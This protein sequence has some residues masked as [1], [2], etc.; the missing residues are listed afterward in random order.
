MVQRELKHLNEMGIVIPRHVGNLCL[1]QADEK[2]PIYSELKSLVIK[3]FGVAGEI[4]NALNTLKEDIQFAFIFGSFAIGEF[5]ARSDIDLLIVTSLSFRK[6]TSA[7]SSVQGILAREINPVVFSTREMREK[8]RNHDGF[9][10]NVING[11][12]IFVLGEENEFGAMVGKWLG[13]AGKIQRHSN[14]RNDGKG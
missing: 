12:K 11:D 5:T 2:S 14:S 3:S 4:K 9:L 6:I 7:L 10:L 1:Y 8:L 13:K